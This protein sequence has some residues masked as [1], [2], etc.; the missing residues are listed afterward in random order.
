M[1]K[2]TTSRQVMTPI[3]FCRIVRFPNIITPNGDGAN[4]VFR[5]FPDKTNG[6][7][8]YQLR[9]V[10][11]TGKIIFTSDSIERGWKGNDVFGNPMP[12][13]T[14][15]YIVTAVGIDGKQF[16]EQNALE[17]RRSR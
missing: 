9:I 3:V 14:Y 1:P 7:E 4:D 5:P 11:K 15:F 10:D 8:S 2:L 13:G 16:N 12:E 6:I 17:L